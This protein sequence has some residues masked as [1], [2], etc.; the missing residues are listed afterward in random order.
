MVASNIVAYLVIQSAEAH[1]SQEH[2]IDHQSWNEWVENEVVVA[3]HAIIYPVAMMIEFVD[4]LIANVAMPRVIFVNG[5]AVWA[6]SLGVI[7]LNKLLE[8]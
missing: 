8:F 2:E 3:T 6:K 7:F 4:T 5:L 1:V